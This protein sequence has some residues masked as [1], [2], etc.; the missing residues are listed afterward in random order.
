MWNFCQRPIGEERSDIELTLNSSDHACPLGQISI[1]RQ[2]KDLLLTRIWGT[3]IVHMLVTQLVAMGL[4]TAGM[5]LIPGLDLDLTGSLV[6]AF[7]FTFSSTVFVIQIMQER[8]EMASRHARLAI[9][10][11][12]IQDLA[13]VLFLAGSTGKIPEWQALWLLL[14]AAAIA[15]VWRVARF[16]LTAIASPWLAIQTLT[17]RLNTTTEPPRML[18]HRREPALLLPLARFLDC[19]RLPLRP[20][21]Q[22]SFDLFQKH[23]LLNV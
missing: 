17:R 15:L 23:I 4:L 1:L 8:G 20:D 11:L 18:S 22:D 19:P 14:A 7:A 12:I 9:G 16:E 21:H 3:T 13:A 10:V 5:Q 2:V 6:I